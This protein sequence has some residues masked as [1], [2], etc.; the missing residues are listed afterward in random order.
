MTDEL[1]VYESVIVLIHPIRI[2]YHLFSCRNLSALA[3]RLQN[4]RLRSDTI[5]GFAP[6][7]ESIFRKKGFPIESLRL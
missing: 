7:R 3:A 6:E 5:A 2:L 1:N 4:M